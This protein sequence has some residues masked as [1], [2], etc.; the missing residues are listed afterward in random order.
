[1][2]ELK[3]CTEHPHGRE[4]VQKPACLVLVGQARSGGYLCSLG[5]DQMA[6]HSGSSRCLRHAGLAPSPLPRGINVAEVA[7]PLL[8]A[9]GQAPGVYQSSHFSPYS[10][11][12]PFARAEWQS[13]LPSPG[14]KPTT[15]PN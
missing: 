5:Q 9:G 7:L 8:P 14:H 6:C 4:E 3:T 12:W 2:A 10:S 11:S 15:L 13:R 1:M